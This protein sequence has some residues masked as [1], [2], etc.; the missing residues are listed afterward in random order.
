MAIVAA[1]I[2]IVY[3]ASIFPLILEQLVFKEIHNVVVQLACVAA[4]PHGSEARIW[5]YTESCMYH[6]YTHHLIFECT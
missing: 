1:A 5:P 3:K 4:C 2:E 6:A